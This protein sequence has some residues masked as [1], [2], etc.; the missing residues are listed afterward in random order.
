MSLLTHMVNSALSGKTAVQLGV[1]E[2]L[3]AFHR[4]LPQSI[5]S[6]GRFCLIIPG[7]CG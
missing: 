5:E 7:V 1:S 3:I 2:R 4:P 6:D